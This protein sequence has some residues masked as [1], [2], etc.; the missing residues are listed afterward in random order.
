[1][2]FKDILVMV[3]ESPA[4][5]ARLG[6]ALALATD[7]DAHVTGLYLSSQPT[8]PAYLDMY[9]TEDMVATL[10][11][12]QDARVARACAAFTEE[13][14]RAGRLERSEW[15]VAEGPIDEVAATHARYADLVV[16]GQ[17]D[18]A[19]TSVLPVVEPETLMFSCGRPVLVVPYAG[20]FATVGR[21][22]LVGWNGSREAARAL[23]DS[24]PILERAR[25][26]TLLTVNTA[27]D[28][29]GADGPAVA[30][31]HHLARHGITAEAAHFICESH[32]IGDTLL[33]CATDLSCDLIVMGGYGQS[34]L[35]S[36][37]LGS[38][39][40]FILRHMTVPVLLSH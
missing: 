4:M 40:G 20:D 9:L 16:V 24:V 2:A 25:K 38:L 33:N 22:V 26:V 12:E 36:M 10:Q 5:A 32:E 13:L 3:D 31:A 8:V 35:R 14:R 29:E 11:A 17:L 15:R 23:G 27:D 7:H 28:A 30:I 19:A 1:M 18:P 39:T 21:R 37:I 34:R 6:A